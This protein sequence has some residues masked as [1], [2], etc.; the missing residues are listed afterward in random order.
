MTRL[1]QHLK[2]RFEGSRI[3]VWHDPNG[4]YEEEAAAMAADLGVNYRAVVN[5][6][7]AVKYG[8]LR[9]DPEGNY[10]LYRGGPVPAST[11][12]WLLDVELAHAVFTADRVNLIAEEMGLEDEDAKAVLRQYRTF[13]NAKDR[14][15]RLKNLV[16]GKEDATL[17]QAKMCAVALG[18]SEHDY[19]ELVRTLLIENAEG[20]GGKYQELVRFGLVDFFWAGAQTFYGYDAGQPSV[21]DLVLWWF[22]KASEGFP[23]TTAKVAESRALEVDFHAMW[24]SLRSAPAMKTLAA[25][26]S[27]DLR[28]AETIEGVPYT[29]L[30]DDMLFEDVERAI[31]RGLSSDVALGSVTGDQ[32]RAYIQKRQ[33]APWFDIYEGEY[34]GLAAAADLMTSVAT[35]R[36]NIHSF[37]EGLVGYQTKWFAIDQSYRHFLFYL[38]GAGRPASLQKVEGPVESGYLDY[39]ARLGNSWQDQVDQMDRWRSNTLDMQSG[40]YKNQVEPHVAGGRRK[41]VVIISDALRYEVG[42]ELSE[43]IVALDKFETDLSAMLGVI[44]SYTQLGMAALLPHKTLGFTADADAVLVDGVRSDDTAQRAKILAGVGGI[45]LQAH[46]VEK[47]KISDLREIYTNN[48]VI[49]VYQNE[50]DN[51]GENN[52]AGND[53]VEAAA[54]AVDQLVGLVKQ[55]TSANATNLWITADH[56]FLFRASKP[57]PHEYLSRKPG[58]ETLLKIDHRFVLGKKLSH[59]DSLRHFTGQQA[60]FEGDVEVQLP[61]SN[62]PLLRPGPGGRYTHGGGTLQEIVVP[63]IRVRKKRTTDVEAVEVSLLSESNRIT[64]DKLNV[65]AYQQRAVG[66]KIHARTLRATLYAGKVAI[67]N[68]EEMIFNSESEVDGERYRSVMLTLLPAADNYNHQSVQL[69]LEEQTPGTNHWNTY[70]NAAYTLIRGFTRDF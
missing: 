7:F 5:N 60:G 63:L 43:K 46:E 18:Q 2:R 39:L 35:F 50:I 49:Y 11:N 53:L 12:N 15:S 54:K 65:R 27:S 24:D 22:K 36:P 48:Q 6:E 4:E 31:V 47:M 51:R 8:V 29:N 40:F 69:C 34:L 28:Y 21:D 20:E 55:W 52:P 58:G 16:G 67:S 1:H 66:G 61:R 14:T 70:R 38:E 56:G 44:P 19:Q 59:D 30:L 26:A 68:S 41:A 10:L 3:V 45:A 23:R 9:E 62:Y 37:D 57:A 13:L 25:R 64:T 32:V 17:L 42:Q 33:L